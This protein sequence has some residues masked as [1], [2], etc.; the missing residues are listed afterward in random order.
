MWGPQRDQASLEDQDTIFSDTPCWEMYDEFCS[1]PEPGHTFVDT[2][3][4]RIWGISHGP[5]RYK[6]ATS[7]RWLKYPQISEAPLRPF[8]GQAG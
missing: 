2:D 1:Q 4:I 6:I 3:L 8:V 5:R 7:G